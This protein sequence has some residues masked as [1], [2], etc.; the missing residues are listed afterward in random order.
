M[1]QA[2]LSSAVGILHHFPDK[3]VAAN[4][5]SLGFLGFCPGDW[6]STLDQDRPEKL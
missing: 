6:L 2:N 5:L 4:G 3:I 1:F